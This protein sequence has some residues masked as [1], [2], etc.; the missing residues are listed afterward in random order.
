MSKS[1]EVFAEEVMED[2]LSRVKSSKDNIEFIDPI[3]ILMIISITVG[4]IRAIQE[5]RKNNLRNYSHNEVTDYLTTDIKF[6]SMNHGF[7]TRW[8]LSRLIKKY[9]NKEQYSYYGDALMRSILE[10]GRNI[11]QDV[12]FDALKII[13][14]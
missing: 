10:C 6:Q 3:T 7:I 1:I 13:Q 2:M 11:N 5:C 4:I 8:K 12:I 9:L 14:E